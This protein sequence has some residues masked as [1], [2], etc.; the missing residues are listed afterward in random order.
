MSPMRS[1]TSATRT[2]PASSLKYAGCARSRRAATSSIRILR[3]ADGENPAQPSWASRYALTCF[4]ISS[5][6]LADWFAG[7][8]E[9][10]NREDWIRPLAPSGAFGAIFRVDLD[11]ST[12]PVSGGQLSLFTLG[13]RAHAGFDNVA[14]LDK[15]TLLAAEDRGDSLHAQLNTLD[16]VWS[17]DVE[18]GTSKRFVALGRTASSA[19]DAGMV[20]T[21]GFQNDGDEEPTGVIASDGSMSRLSILGRDAPGPNSRIFFTQQHGDNQTY[22]VFPPSNQGPAGPPGPPGPQGPNGTPGPTGP[23]GPKGAR[24]R[25]GKNGR[26]AKVTCRVRRRKVTCKVTFTNRR[27]STRARAVLT[28]GHRVYASGTAGR[29]VARRAIRRGRYTLTLTYRGHRERMPVTIR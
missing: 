2:R 14:F 21:T 8:N 26:D 18:S 11:N 15:S 5:P 24:G 1:S 6:T 4:T 12:D 20:G 9:A 13:D 27:R 16:S 29:L 22:E 3:T 28:R 25:S 10:R 7:Y 17:Y 23:P 19:A